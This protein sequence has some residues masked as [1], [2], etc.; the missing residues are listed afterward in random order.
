MRSGKWLDCPDRREYHTNDGL[1]VEQEAEV[2]RFLIFWTSLLFAFAPDTAFAEKRVALV[3]GNAAYQNLPQLP[4]PTRDAKAIAELFR[5]AGFQ[6]VEGRND[7]GGQEFKRALRDFGRQAVEADIAV[8]FYAGRGFQIGDENYMVPI[9][10]KMGR[11][12][13]A[14]EEAISLGRILEALKPAKRR[15]V[16]LDADRDNPFQS[17]THPP[18]VTMKPS[19]AGYGDTLIAYAAKAGSHAQ[20]GEGEHSPFTTALLK[21]LG[22]PGLDIRLALGRVRDDVRMSTGGQQEPFFEGLGAENL[23]LV[24]KPRHAIAPGYACLPGYQRNSTG[25]CMRLGDYGSTR[26][27]LTGRL[28]RR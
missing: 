18:A 2:F 21:H 8:V 7:L 22:E 11:E 27:P 14:K 23:S 6:I 13:D 12:D 28:P 26:P 4:N 9:D 15:L 5:D 19:H 20:D 1:N 25:E 17:T 10:A 24:S 16:F 3:I